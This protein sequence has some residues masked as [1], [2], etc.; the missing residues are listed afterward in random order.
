MAYVIGGFGLGNFDALGQ[1]QI[2]AAGSNIRI[3]AATGNLVVGSADANMVS[4]GLDLSLARTYNSQASFNHHTNDNWRF[5][6]EREIQ[7]S[8]EQLHRITG[9]GHVA[10]FSLSE[11]GQY[12]STAGKGA[13]DTLALMDGEW[14]YTEG[15]SKIKEYYN[16]ESGRLV[17]SEDANGNLTQYEYIDNRLASLISASGEKLS[18][19]YNDQRQLKRIDSYTLENDELTHSHSKVY[20]DYDSQGRLDSVTVD[21]SPEDKSIADGQVFTTTYTYQD[22][23]SPLLKTISQSNGSQVSLDYDLSGAEPQL[24]TI[25]DN[26]TLTRF[27]KPDA[28]TLIVTDPN[29]Q[30]W[31]YKLDSRGRIT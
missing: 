13:H 23:A 7:R 3:N 30:R 9:D 2:S 18:F 28:E 29:N 31:T 21:L 11:N 1:G 14:V 19:Y 22:N 15:T 10:V 25:D 5:S 26:G 12:A 24:K 27:D 20:Y 8:G 16:A 6:F 17:R 4:K